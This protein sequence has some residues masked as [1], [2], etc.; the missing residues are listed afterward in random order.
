MLVL[1]EP[2]EAVDPVSA[3]AIIQIL[4][5]F[6]SRGGTVVLSS[7][8]MDTV[9]KLCTHVAVINAG[10]RSGLRDEWRQVADGMDLNERFVQLV[11]G[12]MQH[13]EMTWLQ[14]SSN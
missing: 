1:D 8:V 10:R 4:H 12:P 6:V 2:F 9:A 11:G 14:P 5:E 7:H 13:E 3:Q